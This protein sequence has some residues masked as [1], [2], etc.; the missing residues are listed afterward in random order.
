MKTIKAF[1]I[2][3]VV[4]LGTFFWVN[5]YRAKLA[6]Q[7][8]AQLAVENRR[9][10]QEAARRREQA[11]RSFNLSDAYK[12]PPISYL[13]TSEKPLYGRISPLAGSDSTWGGVTAQDL[14]A[15]LLSDDAFNN[16]CAQAQVAKTSAVASFARSM[17]MFHAEIPRLDAVDKYEGEQRVHEL[18]RKQSDEICEPQ[19]QSA[20]KA[21]FDERERRFAALASEH[22]LK[23][24]ARDVRVRILD[25]SGHYVKLTVI[26]GDQAGQT[27]FISP[28]ELLT[29]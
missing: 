1:V 10:E 2:T 13:E 5:Q 6:L 8:Q 12:Q 15:K 27:L 28:G 4:G 16:S 29:K 17:W 22:R 23:A 18:I 21:A 19:R 7:E 9:H 3:I 25:I 20:V 14:D 24:L 26:D 11:E